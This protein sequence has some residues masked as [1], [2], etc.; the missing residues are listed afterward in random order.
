MQIAEQAV[1]K[2]IALLNAA[3]CVNGGQV[4]AQNVALELAERST[5][6]QYPAVQVYCER[7][8]NELTER[9]RT[10][11]GKA[12]LA[13]EVRYSQDRLEGLDQ[14]V[15]SYAEAIAQVLDANRGDW[16]GGLYYAGGYEI[17]FGP[18]KR[19]GRNFV[20]TGKITFEL[21]VSSN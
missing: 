18:V 10:F 3:G 13:I 4:V 20:Q 2:A 16:T 8:R 15:Q 7:L 19:G 14:R 11:S 21:G 12:S 6:V 9:F 5:D 17:A 1:N